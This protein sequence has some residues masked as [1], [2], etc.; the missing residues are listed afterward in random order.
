MEIWILKNPNLSATPPTIVVTVSGNG[1]DPLYS[2][3][4]VFSD[5]VVGTCQVTNGTGAGPASKTL[6]VNPNGGAGFDTSSEASLGSS[7]IAEGANQA[8]L[9]N[10]ASTFDSGIAGAAGAGSVEFANA[11]SSITMTSS[12]STSLTDAYAYGAVPI[13]PAN[14]RRGEVIIGRLMPP[15]EPA[16]PSAVADSMK[17]KNPAFASSTT[18]PPEERAVIYNLAILPKR[19]DQ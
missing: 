15:E 9:W 11:S 16:Q 1:T 14:P 12:Y 19:E 8:T 2:G 18:Q 4:A 3:A 17:A 13:N 5:A 10:F 6:T 7:A